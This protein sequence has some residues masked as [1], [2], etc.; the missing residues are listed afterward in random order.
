MTKNELIAEFN[1][2]P[3]INSVEH[4]YSEWT[5]RLPWPHSR[6]SPDDVLEKGKKH[7]ISTVERK[8]RA[9][10]R[11]YKVEKSIELDYN[12]LF[13]GI[14]SNDNWTSVGL[15]VGV[16]A[17]LSILAGGAFVPLV[18]AGLL[19]G[20]I[21]KRINKMKEAKE[22]LVSLS[23][24][25]AE[26]YAKAFLEIMNL[27]MVSENFSLPPAITSSASKVFSKKL[28]AKQIQIKNFLDAR[29][30]KYLLHFTNSD[31]IES[32]K[33]HGI[34][35]VDELNRRGLPYS[36]ND[37]NRMDRELDYIS[38]SV[39]SINRQLLGSY[40]YTD[41]IKNVSVIYI[42]ASILYEEIDTPRIYCDRN[43]AA[44][45]CNK[46]E[47]F[48]EFEDM[49]KHSINYATATSV[50]DYDRVRDGRAKNEP[51]DPQAEILFKGC[52][53]KKYIMYIRRNS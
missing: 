1:A 16:G 4:W 41:R 6:P 14:E 38:L 52:V 39:T 7:I 36:S 28:T 51:T 25:C 46:G 42:S 30:I 50:R 45:S 23:N 29:G 44:S 10:F 35:S 49:F 24:D 31:N 48:F 22:E 15:G 18:A 32:I 20:G 34:L 19:V 43:A 26:A 12:D 33:E 5:S 9:M 37:S 13:S 40:L 3:N 17:T 47:S 53:P 2:F 21:V 27:K 8:K 11:K